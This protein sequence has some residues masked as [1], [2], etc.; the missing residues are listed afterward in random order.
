LTTEGNALKELAPYVRVWYVRRNRREAPYVRPLREDKLLLAYAAVFA[1]KASFRMMTLRLT[2]RRYDVV[3]VHCTLEALLMTVLRALLRTPF[4][5]VFEGYTDWEARAA[6]Y[7]DIQI[8]ISSDI[9]ERCS[10]RHGYRPIVIPVGV[11]Q[12][13]FRVDGTK[14][15]KMYSSGDEKIVLTV[16]RL[17]PRK[18]IP[19]LVRA[20]KLVCNRNQ[21]VKFLIAGEGGEEAGIRKLIDDLNLSR[22]VILVKEVPV[23]PAFYAASDLFVLPSRYEGFG[24]V[25]LEAM[26]AGV[27]I[28]STTAPAIPEVVGDAG[29]LVPP[30]N[31]ELLAEEILRLL[32]DEKLR[33]DL[34]ERGL[35][36]VG[37]Y[38]WDRLITQ[39]EKVYASVIKSQ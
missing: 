35:E 9:A 7:A 39:Y 14:I 30:G 27:P 10:S 15:R 38:D 24:I 36:R 34:A 17:D 28:I 3:S 18:D 13:K 4:V 20:A 2:G 19:T 12:S 21:H 29:L 37:R 1:V 8:A 16:C 25:F 6:K 23:H 33:R 26:S 22:K 11:D 5:F 31:S 32:K